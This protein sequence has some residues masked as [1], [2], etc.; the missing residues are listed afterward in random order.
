MNPLLIPNVFVIRLSGYRSIGLTFEQAS[1]K[2]N[3][4][5]TQ[6]YYQFLNILH[7]MIDVLEN[8]AHQYPILS[9]IIRTISKGEFDTINRKDISIV[10]SRIFRYRYM[11]TFDN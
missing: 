8:N 11:N 2:L 3:I 4:E 1:Q 9:S 10:K 7:F 6:Y 5:T